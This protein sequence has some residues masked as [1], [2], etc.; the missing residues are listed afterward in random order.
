VS[1]A[2]I[3]DGI[4]NAQVIGVT[5]VPDL[6]GAVA[7]LQFSPQAVAGTLTPRGSGAPWTLT[8]ELTVKCAV[9]KADLHA[10]QPPAGGTD[11]TG[12]LFADETFTAP[13]CASLRALAG[14]P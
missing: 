13:E 9:P 11:G 7:T 14:L 5:G 2:P 3:A 4:A 12:A 8:A 1:S 6:E 10:S